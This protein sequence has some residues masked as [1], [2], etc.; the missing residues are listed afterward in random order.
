MK[1]DMLEY[2]SPKKDFCG[3]RKERYSEIITLVWYAFGGLRVYEHFYL[4]L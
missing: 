1:S 3:R 2:G 4:H